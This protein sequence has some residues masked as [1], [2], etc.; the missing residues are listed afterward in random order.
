V[1]GGGGGRDRGGRGD[2]YVQY[3]ATSL[4]I[5]FHYRGRNKDTVYIYIVLRKTYIFS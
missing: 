5:C 4:T 3:L 1:N 2:M